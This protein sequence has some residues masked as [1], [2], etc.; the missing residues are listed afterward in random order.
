MDYQHI[1]TEA[2]GR[3]FILTF[4][5]D[6]T[7]NAV[8]MRMKAEIREA[9]QAFEANDDLWVAVITHNGSCFCSGTDLK[10]KDAAWA[11]GN[12]DYDK[13][14][15][16]W[17]FAALTRHVFSKPV[18]GAVNGKV[19]GGGAEICLSFDMLVASEDSLFGFPEVAVGLMADQGGLLQIM[20]QLPYKKA[21]ELLF[22]GGSISAAE[23]KEY[24]LVNHVTPKGKAQDKALELAEAICKNAPLAVRYSKAIALR[25]LDST[26]FYPPSGWDM[27]KHY[28]DINN[29]TEDAV[30]GMRAFVEK[31]PPVWKG[32]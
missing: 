17:G 31:R 3:I 22:T 32:K 26:V 23:A 12:I 24:G 7:R 18:I 29:A 13:E 21:L 28:N 5:R 4:N 30:E 9:M 20:R 19:L 10:E 27:V 16:E 8:N 11:A 2:R 25:G 15:D 1:I 6:E 14:D